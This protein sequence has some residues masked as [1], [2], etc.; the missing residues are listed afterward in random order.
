[1]LCAR[2]LSEDSKD[3]ERGV[4]KRDANSHVS[5]PVGGSK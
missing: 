5:R 3:L 1:M 4:I 2:D